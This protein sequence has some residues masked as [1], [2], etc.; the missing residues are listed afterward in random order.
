[1]DTLWPF[2]I[3]GRFMNCPIGDGTLNAAGSSFAWAICAGRG[4]V[5]PGYCFSVSSAVV[6]DRSNLIVVLRNPVIPP[7][8]SV[9]PNLVYGR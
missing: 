3:I 2:V 5:S 4:G 8:K 9:G 1:M 7:L 6:G